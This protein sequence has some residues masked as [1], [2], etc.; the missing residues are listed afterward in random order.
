[1]RVLPDWYK[2]PDALFQAG[3]VLELRLRATA[4]RPERVA[5]RFRDAEL[6]GDAANNALSYRLGG[7]HAIVTFNRVN[8]VF[9]LAL[10]TEQAILDR[11]VN[12]RMECGICFSDLDAVATRAL[13]CAHILCASCLASL[14]SR[15][16]PFCREAI[17]AVLNVQDE[18]KRAAEELLR[19]KS[20]SAS[21]VAPEDEQELCACMAA[22]AVTTTE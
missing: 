2:N 22:C 14:R 17:E 21:C 4:R 15:T 19:A 18:L 10:T 1:M 3:D 13:Q 8:R 12:D 11:L 7:S 9:E 6:A 16:C 20:E 5:S